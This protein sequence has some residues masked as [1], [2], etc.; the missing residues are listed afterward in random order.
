MLLAHHHYWLGR[1]SLRAKR[2]SGSTWQPR[3]VWVGIDIDKIIRLKMLHHEPFEN[4]QTQ[5]EELE[6]PKEKRKWS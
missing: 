1:H 4:L 5:N 6:D 2:G 3:R